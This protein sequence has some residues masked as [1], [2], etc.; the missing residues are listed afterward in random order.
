MV[1]IIK[2]GFNRENL[3]QFHA[4]KEWLDLVSHYLGDKVAPYAEGQWI[5][6]QLWKISHGH[7]NAKKLFDKILAIGLSRKELQNSE[8]FIKLLQA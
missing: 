3:I 2:N 8:D 6:S 7:L 4:Y 1:R 5:A